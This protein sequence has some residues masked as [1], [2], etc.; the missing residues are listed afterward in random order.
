MVS[1]TKSRQT[2]HKHLL[3]LYCCKVSEARTQIEHSLFADIEIPSIPRH[4]LPFP[5]PREQRIKAHNQSIQLQ[6]GIRPSKA[7]LERKSKSIKTEFSFLLATFVSVITSYHNPKQVATLLSCY[8]KRLV[9]D[10]NDPDDILQVLTKNVTFIDC[11]LLQYI[12]NTLPDTELSHL[13]QIYTLDLKK[14]LRERMLTKRVIL[15]DS[16]MEI[17][18]DDKQEIKK[19]K[20]I[21]HELTNMEIEVSYYASKMIL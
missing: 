8:D 5:S 18:R 21:A 19:W 4:Y 10:T 15:L 20:S 17:S 14:Y 16:K 12:A 1:S 9:A 11:D 13:V 7:H 3:L 2:L 6:H